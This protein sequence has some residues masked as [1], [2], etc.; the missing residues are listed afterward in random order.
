M[1]KIMK[2]LELIFQEVFDN[3]SIIITPLTTAK[4]IEDWDSFMQMQ[5]IV[6]AESE[7]NIKFSVTD[8]SHLKNVGDFV[9]C[10]EKKLENR[11]L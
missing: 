7:F 1:N 11:F 8:V 2:K 6:T 10:I 9:A 3:E 5:L 4:D